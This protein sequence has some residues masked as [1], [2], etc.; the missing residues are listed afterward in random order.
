MTIASEKSDEQIVLMAAA[1]EKRD[2]QI[3]ELVTLQAINT[4]IEQNTGEHMIVNHSD[5][6]TTGAELDELSGGGE[7]ALHS[8]AGAEKY[9]DRGNDPG[10]FDFT[11]GN[12]THDGTWRDFD[13]SSIVPEG[14]TKVRLVIRAACSTVS[15]QIRF[16]EN[17][18]TS[19]YVVENVR[20]IVANVRICVPA[21][22]V[23]DNNR[24]IEYSSNLSGG[25]V[26][27]DVGVRGWWI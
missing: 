20:T 16:R 7:T 6:T 19:D 14:A 1:S 27:C 13:L 25:T 21:E 5:T 9:V 3:A 8:H 23:L 12:F 15:R 24:K 2:A 26:I 4:E 11:A 17:G 18:S 22:C 10:S